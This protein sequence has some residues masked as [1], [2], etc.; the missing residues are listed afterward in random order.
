[1][2][3]RQR[4]P[5]TPSL[6]F[7]ALPDHRELSK[8]KPVRALLEPRKRAS[9]RNSA[10][11]I[12]VRHRGGGHKRHYRVIDF[13]RDK[14]GIPAK[15]VH[16]EYDPNRSAHLALL[17][18]RDGEKR[19]IIAPA[20]LHAGAKVLSG[21][22]V[23]PALGNALPLRLIPVGVT[24]HNLESRPGSGAKL[25]RTAGAGAQM[26]ARDGDYANVKMPSGEIRRLHADCYAVVGAVGN[27]EHETRSLGKAGRKRWLGIRPTVRGVCMNPIDHPNGGGE[28]RSKSG[29]GR[30]HLMSPWGKLARGKKT[31]ARNNPTG[32]FIVQ[33]RK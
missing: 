7:T 32:K 29:G 22:A 14:H 2:P 8:E 4:K 24:V 25:V 9:G 19:Y 23:E 28:G 30:Q 13:R 5:S 27:S 21:P 18:Y 16:L 10:G 17:A 15:V 26:M 1:M 12:T 6:R 3:I 31:R 11:R 20:G 33:R